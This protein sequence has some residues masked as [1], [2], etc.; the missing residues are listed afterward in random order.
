MASY[1]MANVGGFAWAF[2]SEARDETDSHSRELPDLAAR[3][4]SNEALSLQ[5]RA[6]GNG[7]GVVSQ[8]NNADGTPLASL[9]A[10][11]ASGRSAKS[12]YVQAV[13]EYQEKKPGSKQNAKN[14]FNYRERVMMTKQSDDGI[15]EKAERQ[16]DI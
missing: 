7:T 15:E 2:L 14:A 4:S 5:E 8:R 10:G 6:A 13:D 16:C 1:A 3:G 9:G 11:V 12:L